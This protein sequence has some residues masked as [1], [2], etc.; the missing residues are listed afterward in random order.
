MAK[1]NLLS[2]RDNYLGSRFRKATSDLYF[3]LEHTAKALLI[4]IGVYPETHK[5]VSRMLSYHFVRPGTI[6]LHVVIH[7]DNLYER[8]KT[9]EYSSKAGWEFTKEQIDTYM[10]WVRG[11]VRIIIEE[12]KKTIE[13]ESLKDLEKLITQL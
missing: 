9:A 13:H 4:S 11:S 8:R 1:E 3:G 7:L 5:G 2:F 12:L 10:E 6:P